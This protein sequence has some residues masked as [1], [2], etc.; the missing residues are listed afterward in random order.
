MAQRVVQA[1]GGETLGQVGT[2]AGRSGTIL[3]K[4]RER[5][6]PEVAEVAELE[7]GVS[8]APESFTDPAPAAPTKQM[9]GAKESA[10]TSGAGERSIRGKSAKTGGPKPNRG[11]KTGTVHSSE[12]LVP[13]S[14]GNG[15][16]DSG[17]LRLGA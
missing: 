1:L 4:L 2:H 9:V 6:E 5:T 17:G 10:I 16:G 7:L 12:T 14:G 11:A 15:H 8:S 13:A 3:S